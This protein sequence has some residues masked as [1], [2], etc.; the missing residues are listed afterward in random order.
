MAICGKH[1]GEQGWRLNPCSRY[2]CSWEAPRE[3]G[4]ITG[5]RHRHPPQTFKIDPKHKL[6]MDLNTTYPIGCGMT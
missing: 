3:Q 2:P 4:V 6:L 1:L 5:K